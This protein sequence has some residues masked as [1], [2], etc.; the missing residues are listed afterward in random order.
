MLGLAAR[1]LDTPS[2]YKI[3]RWREQTLV[4]LMCALGKFLVGHCLA[5]CGTTDEYQIESETVAG[6]PM[7][8]GRAMDQT[9]PTN[10]WRK[11]IFNINSFRPI[12]FGD[13]LPTVF[14][15]WINRRV[16]G[17]FD[18]SAVCTK[19][20]GGGVDFSLP[21]RENERGPDSFRPQVEDRYHG[22][23]VRKP[24]MG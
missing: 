2:G 8:N 20:I 13:S 7:S 6:P 19:F 21:W 15:P 12:F 14:F 16:R 9:V 11:V 1:S 3:K 24:R 10:R 4:L 17:T 22:R 18:A 23:A 5:T